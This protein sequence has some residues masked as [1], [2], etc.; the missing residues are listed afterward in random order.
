[1]L[2]ANVLLTKL[3][4]CPNQLNSSHGDEGLLQMT[5]SDLLECPTGLMGILV[6]KQLCVEWLQLQRTGSVP[7]DLSLWICPPES[8]PLDLSP[9]ICPPISPLTPGSQEGVAHHGLHQEL[10]GEFTR[11]L[12]NI[13]EVI[14]LNLETRKRRTQTER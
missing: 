2:G 4:A 8:V 6:S 9:W 1:M 11:T 12:M 13:N 3:R 14:E 5:A 10:L 7:L